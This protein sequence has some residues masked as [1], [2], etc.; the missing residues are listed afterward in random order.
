MNLQ[1]SIS[2]IKGVGEKKCRILNNMGVETVDDML[3]LFPRKYE[4]RREISYI[5]EA[6]FNKDVLVKGRVAAR[7]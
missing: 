7:Q 1:D 6:P 5:M 4:D 3:H 2:C